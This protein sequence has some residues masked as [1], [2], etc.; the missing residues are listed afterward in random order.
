METLLHPRIELESLGWDTFFETRFTRYRDHDLIPARIT[1][2]HKGSYLALAEV[3]E[4]HAVVAGRMRYDASGQADLPVVGDWV[5]VEAR[6]DGSATIK[7]IVERRTKFSR[8]VAG[9]EYDEQILAANIDATFL[10]SSLNADLN[11]RRL[12]RYLTMAYANGALPVVVL[13]KADLC[14][15]VATGFEQ[16]ASVAVGAPIHV[17]SAI[18]G[19]GLDELR[20]YLARNQTVALLGSSGVGKSTLVNALAGEEL[21]K[22]QEIR[23]DD[24]K[25][26]HTTTHRQMVLLPDGGIIIDTP[27]M[28]ELQL[29]DADQGL[30]GSF[31]DIDA[32]AM[33][34]RFRDCRHVS[35]PG[36][37]VRAAV[38]AG[39]L[40]TE[41]LA[42][43]KKLQ[44][45]LLYLERKIDQR[46]AQ[47]ETRKWKVQH[48]AMRRMKS[49]K[50]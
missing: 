15:D 6:P 12:E 42:S 21:L 7:A 11:P 47:E 41:R 35:E 48:K 39:D 30:R 50:V 43:F 49:P 23:E 13:T 8:K 45:E 4:L 10:V 14:D 20:P 24:A 29:W 18:T 1:T 9:F 17:V 19:N 28:R 22:V 31:Q 37:A 25:G 40:A 46:I 16:V 27:G 2:Q 32:L 33:E 36:C 5:V 38:D 26:R 3:G 44:R 34:C